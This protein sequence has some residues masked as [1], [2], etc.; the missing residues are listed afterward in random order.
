MSYHVTILRTAGGAQKAIG[1][2]ELARVVTSRPD[3]RIEEDGSGRTS[4][5]RATGADPPF[6]VFQ[7]GEIWSSNPERATLT[8]MLELAVALDARVRGDEFETYRTPDE[9]YTHPDDRETIDL[10]RREGSS[11]RRRAQ[12]A[13]VAWMTGFA[14]L[15]ALVGVVVQRCTAG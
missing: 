7:N 1:R 12:L 8:L 11:M 13:S 3:L 4:I 10:A 15:A 6:L 14:L 2:G 5:R 9:T